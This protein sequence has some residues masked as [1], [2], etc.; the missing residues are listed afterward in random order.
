MHPLRDDQV[1]CTV[2]DMTSL[3]VASGMLLA[4][5]YPLGKMVIQFAGGLIVW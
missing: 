4:L 5:T 1:C 2:C 3:V